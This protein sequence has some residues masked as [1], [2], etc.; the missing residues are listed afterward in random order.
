MGRIAAIVAVVLILGCGGV[1]TNPAPTTVPAE[2]AD[3]LKSKVIAALQKVVD[4]PDGLEIL[5][6]GELRD[7]RADA[8]RGHSHLAKVS[9][10]CKNRQGGKQVYNWTAY[11][12][13]GR[14]A[15]FVDPDPAGW[16]FREVPR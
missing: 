8:Y 2:E 12:N 4:D 3:P 15:E 14:V 16:V 9:F 13:D 11:L 1:A 10:R 6:L 7:I 5:S